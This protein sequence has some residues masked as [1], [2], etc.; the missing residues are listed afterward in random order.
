[1]VNTIQC[2][3][4]GRT[5]ERV[6]DFL[7]LCIST[8]GTTCLQDGLG[9]LFLAEE[10]L[11]ASNQYYCDSCARLT[12]AIKRT[13]LR[14]LP[15]VL[16]VSI[17]R[18]SFDPVKMDRVKETGRFAFP[19]QLDMSPF[20]EGMSLPVA[21]DL[22]AGGESV[23]IEMTSSNGSVDGVTNHYAAGDG[24]TK[25]P[26]LP[27]ALYE[28]FSVVVHRGGAH[29]GH[30]HALIKDVESLGIWRNPEDAPAET[31][32]KKSSEKEPVTAVAANSK[33]CDK[34][35]E[36]DH[37]SPQSVITAC[38]K[39][40][41]SGG[42]AISA[43]SSEI[44]QLTGISWKN[45]FKRK[46]GSL[47][48]FIH[49]NADRFE[50]NEE[51]GWVSLSFRESKLT[52]AI[53]NGATQQHDVKQSEPDFTAVSSV[54][55]G[56][57][58][59]L[60]ESNDCESMR[61]V[62]V[63]CLEKAC[64]GGMPIDRLSSE[65]RQATGF[66]W[67]SHFKKKLGSLQEFILNNSDQFDFDVDTHLVSI[68]SRE[69]NAD[70]DIKQH[71][72]KQSELNG[73][74][75]E[76]VNGYGHCYHD[77]HPSLTELEA[78]R[79][80]VEPQSCAMRESKTSDV[81]KESDPDCG[82]FDFNDASVR[83]ITA[84]DVEKQFMGKECAYMLFYRA[85]QQSKETSLTDR[86]SGIPE[87]FVK[88][89][90][91]ENATLRRQRQEHDEKVNMV[92]VEIHFGRSYEY[93]NGGIHLRSDALSYLE[94]SIDRRMTVADLLEVISELGGEMIGAE[95]QTIHVARRLP[96]GLH[97]Y[98]DITGDLQ[99]TLASSGISGSTKLFVWDGKQ[100]GGLPVPVGSECEPVL[101]S[102]EMQEVKRM[103]FALARN[104]TVND[105]KNYVCKET[106][107]IKN[108]VRLIDK[109]SDKMLDCDAKTLN[110]AGLHM[111][112]NIIAKYLNA[113]NDGLSASEL[114]SSHVS[115][116]PIF[117]SVQNMVFHIENR[118]QGEPLFFDIEVDS[119]ATV[120]ELKLIAF[121]AA[122]IP[123]ECAGETRLRVE[124]AGT[125]VLG[126]PLHESAEIF[127]MGLSNGNQLILEPGR[128][129][130]ATQI[131][132]TVTVP[133][134]A[135]IE[136][137]VERDI[138]VLQLQQ[139]AV[140]S[141][142]VSDGEW[143]LCRADWASEAG[144]ILSADQTLY[145]C[146][147]H[148]GDHL[149]LQPGCPPPPGFIKLDVYVASSEDAS[150][151]V[152][153]TEV[154]GK[155]LVRFVKNGSVVISKLS[156]LAELKQQ[157]ATLDALCCTDD[158]SV[159]CIRLRILLPELRPGNILR[160][161]GETLQKLKLV[162]GMSV[163]FE[164]LDSEEDLSSLQ[165][166]LVIRRRIPG[167]RMYSDCKLDLIWDISQ[168]ATLGSLR[169]AV[170]AAIGET[171]CSI[172]IAKHFPEKF[173]W[174][175]ITDQSNADG[176]AQDRAQVGRKKGKK[177]KKKVP[178]KN[179]TGKSTDLRQAPYCL[180]DLDVLGVKVIFEDG[181]T[182]DD[183]A[184]SSDDEGLEELRRKRADLAEKRKDAKYTGAENQTKRR[185]E[186]EIRIHV[187]NFR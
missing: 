63:G 46:H 14:R 111:R 103:E 98:Q 178:N 100:V 32:T 41:G 142:R 30:Y 26:L 107:W 9:M 47:P 139:L 3:T 29:G 121:S 15:P 80:P 45:R 35:L 101:I 116:S 55:Q 131:V 22:M 89:V 102:I 75:P 91:E 174:R 52:K 172:Q 92:S 169:R 165:V 71:D 183:F 12:D 27:Q 70:G 154:N 57:G 122:D 83:C 62:I 157:I 48:D 104:S 23:R 67:K 65:I 125:L 159:F 170:S 4:C 108:H 88:E 133:P 79:A 143:H 36:I 135:D 123:V 54:R 73:S 141:G 166:P 86:L 84:R 185:P 8:A 186:T 56:N 42:M 74:L 164:Q 39:K 109:K 114:K 16:T 69:A 97:L 20:C 112:A 117:S 176:H 59:A 134:G 167:K 38:L 58:E 158:T 96:A 177:N 6:E 60:E 50:L 151:S 118:L 5:S 31:A 132:V 72:A 173:E 25:G 162:T 126:P 10:K 78:N 147:L 11:D 90:E 110:E 81:S 28:L 127:A 144:A 175:I 93:K 163:V 18:F 82:W 130:T 146:G 128:P 66:P 156:T 113:A 77:N 7:D 161:N 94:H 148:H 95:D 150:L 13:K 137:N 44:L 85:V 21:D 68:R 43:L 99:A 76:S 149:L 184:T 17:L 171:E 51:A 49:N 124:D 140:D 168:G 33:K 115:T 64:K 160:P 120:A 136:L 61:S 145:D 181:G 155:R 119:N 129:P 106:G 105:L 152:N 87:A 1:M 153:E 19:Q 182:N 2:V 187:D 34:P 180:Q 138:T 179:S 24:V 53:A 37:E 40:A